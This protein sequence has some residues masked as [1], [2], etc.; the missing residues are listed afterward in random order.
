VPP[1]ITAVAKN[2]DGGLFSGI[3]LAG[4]VGMSRAYPELTT[5]FNAKGQRMA[6]DIAKMCID[7]YLSA[8]SFERMDTYT[9]V[10]DAIDLPWVQEIMELNRL[11]GRTPGAP[12]FVYQSVNDELIPMA[13]VNDLI[14]EYCEEGVTVAYYQDLASEHITLA[15]TGGP[16]AVSHLASR[17]A[18]APAPTTCALPRVPPV[19]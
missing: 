3:V 9:T 16:L 1:N 18:G 10:P 5:L 17:F 11:G 19:T 8:Y 15:F 13:D 12:L 2:L 7:E 6:G 14:A 4:T